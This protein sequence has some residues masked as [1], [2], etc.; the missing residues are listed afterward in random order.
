MSVPLR[1]LIVEDSED[2]AMLLLRELRKGGY[3]PLWQIVDSAEAMEKALD[4][5]QWDIVLSDFVMSGFS[6]RSAL[7]LLRAKG[8]D[9]PC[10]VISGVLLEETAV[11][12]LKAGASDF[13]KKGNWAR[14]LPAIDRE[15]REAQSRIERKR[16]EM[17]QCEAEEKYRSIFE[18]AVEGIFQASPDGHFISANPALART[19]GYESPRELIQTVTDIRSQLFLKPDSLDQFM[20]LAEEHDKI[21]GFEAQYRR[22]NGSVIWGS[23]S[24]RPV[25][26]K[27]GELLYIEGTLQDIDDRKRAEEEKARLEEQLLQSQK[28][29]AIGTLAGGIA[30][31]FNNLLQAISGNVQLLLFKKKNDDPDVR[32]LMEIDRTAGRAVD[33]VRHLLTFSRKARVLFQEVN[34]N[35]TIEIVLQFLK[36]TVP[37]MISIE[38]QLEDGLFNISADSIQV[39]QILMNLVSNACDAMPH[40]GRLVIE[41]R[42][43]ILGPADAA[44]YL[45]LKAGRHVLLRVLDSGI[46]MDEEIMQHIFEPFFTTKEVGKGTGIGLAAVYGIVKSHGGHISCDSE[47]ERGSIFS[48]Y[49]PAL[50]KRDLKSEQPVETPISLAQGNENILL[51]DD[52]EIILDITEDMLIRCGYRVFKAGSGEEALKIYARE[53]GRIDL[54]ILD[55][56]MPGMGGEKCLEQLLEYDPQAKVIVASGYSAHRIS[57]APHEYG[58]AGFL[59]KPYRLDEM[60]AKIREVLD[61]GLPHASPN[62]LPMFRLP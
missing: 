27:A 55:L 45:G 10:I 46:G 61:Q 28:M 8:V 15:L 5:G 16:A 17:A 54:V 21:S 13:I 58:T 53:K 22:K 14:L 4:E 42:N 30:H 12:L 23:L 18:N 39:E 29:E 47:P 44:K 48:V 52:E 24:A 32:Y 56:G 49:L 25:R 1:V 50:S 34:L 20:Y 9:L 2:D 31:D 19:L 37:K 51:V 3:T 40:G 57:Q 7:D 36:R 41:T 11:D 33:L 60:V 35:K 62:A 59:S 38:L 6:G 26:S 43:A